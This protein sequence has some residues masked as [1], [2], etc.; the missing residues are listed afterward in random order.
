M[1]SAADITEEAIRSRR[2]QRTVD[3]CIALIEQTSGLTVGEAIEI[4][5]EA[6]GV[7]LVLFPGSE[8]TFD[9]L[10]RPRLM[11]AIRERFGI[12]EVPDLPSGP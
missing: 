8:Q 1:Q 12:E 5:L 4:I 6:R 2:L 10:Y 3:L 7:A 11:R 9:L